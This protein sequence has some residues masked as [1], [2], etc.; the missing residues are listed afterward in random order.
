[1]ITANYK[2]ASEVHTGLQIWTTQRVNMGSAMVLFGAFLPPHRGMIERKKAEKHLSTLQSKRFKC[3][4]C[5]LFSTNSFF[6]LFLQNMNI[7]SV[8]GNKEQ[9]SEMQEQKSQANSKLMFEMH[10]DVNCNKVFPSALLRWINWLPAHQHQR[11]KYC[12]TVFQNIQRWKQ[13]KW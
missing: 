7:K 5:V 8:R 12:E 4:C 2:P 6:C 1:M 3:Q 11:C 13:D 9:I 10:L